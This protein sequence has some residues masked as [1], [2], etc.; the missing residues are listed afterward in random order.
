MSKSFKI[1]LLVL[2]LGAA[3]SVFLMGKY[4][5]GL[6]QGPNVDVALVFRD[7]R[8]FNFT[9]K[10]ATPVCKVKILRKPDG[11]VTWTLSSMSESAAGKSNVKTG[12]EFGKGG[13]FVLDQK[14]AS[15]W[16]ADSEQLG[17]ISV[18]GQ[19]TSWR[20]GTLCQDGKPTPVTT[21]KRVFGF[22]NVPPAFREEVKRIF[23]KLILPEETA[24]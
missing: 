14:S 13:F 9:G 21:A 18:E 12:G 20:W 11:S 17:R 7:S 15:L 10:S 23:P 19:N 4:F 5:H 8:E 22:T 16:Y 2:S 6:H 24:Q 3:Y 1:L